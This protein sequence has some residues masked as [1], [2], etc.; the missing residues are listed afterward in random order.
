MSRGKT[1]YEIWME[2]QLTG[3][4]FRRECER[5]LD[6]LRLCSQIAQYREGRGL[7]QAQLERRTGTSRREIDRLEIADYDELP[8]SLLKKVAAVLGLGLVVKVELR[9]MKT[10]EVA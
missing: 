6:K 9:E 4:D 2:S 7:T 3:S 5:A 1:N 8:V 10:R